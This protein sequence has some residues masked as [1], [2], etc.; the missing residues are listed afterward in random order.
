MGAGKQ[1]LHFLGMTDGALPRHQLGR[2]L[3]I[4]PGT[5]TTGA[6]QISEG[7]VD[8]FC[9]VSGFFRV[10][11][12]TLH[13][14]DA[15]G[16]RKLLHVRMAGGTAQ[17]GVDA[18]F[19]LCFVYEEVAPGIGLKATLAVATETIVVSQP[20]FC[21]LRMRRARAGGTQQQNEDYGAMS[22]V[23]HR[24]KT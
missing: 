1:G 3:G 6:C 15:R 4:M 5:V 13:F 12:G 11:G 10:T 24:P 22:Q 8:A 9:S 7:K 19:V 14:R 18:G 16:M 21:S 20:R 17:I 2:R 23:G